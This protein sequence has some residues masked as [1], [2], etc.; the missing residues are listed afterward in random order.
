MVI[1][2]FDIDGTISNNEHRK[3]LLPNCNLHLTSSWSEYNKACSNDEPIATMINMM[4]SLAEA[5]HVYIMTSRSDEVEYETVKWLNDNN[6]EYDYLFMRNRHDNRKDYLIKEGWLERLSDRCK[7]GV[8]IFED[9]PQVIKHLR[10]CGYKVMAVCEYDE[11][12]KD[13]ESH[14]E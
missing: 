6:V 11:L 8:I 12:P 4:N 2:V 9:N 13:C 1:Y 7:D 10:K 3:H 5:S 14:G